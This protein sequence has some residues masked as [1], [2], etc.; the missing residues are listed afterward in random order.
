LTHDR[1]FYGKVAMITGATSGIGRATALAFARAGAQVVLAGRRT[2]LGLELLDEIRHGGG[3]GIFVTTDVAS[4]ESIE[5]L[6]QS[7]RQHFGRLD[8]AFNNAGIAGESLKKIAEH[9]LESWDL[10]MQINLR[11][12]WLSMKHQIPLML[13]SGGGAIVNNASFL[14]KVGAPYGISPY[15]ASKHG[16]IGLSKAVALE[17]AQERIRVNALCPGY[18]QTPMMEPALQAG[19]DEFHAYIK[20]T[21]PMART[22]VADEMARVVMW[23]CSENSSYVTGQAIAADGGIT[24]T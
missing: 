3:D 8:V 20:A 22:A 23:L 15:V 14:G 21:V 1:A 6:C 16:V 9:S 7:T 4:A 13:A 24:A 2:S 17:Y 5:N 19:A 18:T 11:G 12:V 10:V